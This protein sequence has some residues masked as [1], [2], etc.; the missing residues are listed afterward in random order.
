MKKL[1]FV[2]M[3]P[4]IIGVSLSGQEMFGPDLLNQLGLRAEVIEEIQD[5]Q[6]QAAQK[7]KLSNAEMGILKAKLAKVLLE[8]SPDLD[9]VKDLLEESLKYRLQ[10]E[11]ANVELRVMIR[12]K[13]G[14]KKWEELVK[15]RNQL[16]QAQQRAR[17]QTPDGTQDH[18]QTQTTDQTHDRI[19]TPNTN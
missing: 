13:I 12:Q 17:T 18:T 7:M 3:I 1:I 14:N 6:Y 8:E 9:E 4:V 16:T 15:V 19:R 5:M 11:M 10:N 2:L